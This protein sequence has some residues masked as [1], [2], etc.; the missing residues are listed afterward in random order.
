MSDA[1]TPP[2]FRLAKEKR[3]LMTSHL[4]RAPSLSL[5]VELLCLLSSFAMLG[6]FLFLPWLNVFGEGMTG[7][8]LLAEV[9][10]A[11]AGRV[12]IPALIPLAAVLSAL[13]SAISLVRP[14]FSRVNAYLVLAGGLVGVAYYALF[15]I[16]NSRAGS[17]TYMASTGFWLAFLALG[18]LIVQI[19]IPRSGDDLPGLLGA[20]AGEAS[21]HVYLGIFG[22]RS[23]VVLER[24]AGW[25]SSQPRYLA[26]FGWLAILTLIE[27]ALTLVHSPLAT[28]ALVILSGVKVLLVVAYY[29]H[30]K[31][32]SRLFTYIMLAPVPFVVVLL[33]ALLVGL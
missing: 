4:R 21:D 23:A 13:F 24:W 28:P 14:R 11:I 18:V 19:A 7:P 2:F 15:F 27:V 6:A 25:I 31:D 5:I 17:I 9:P 33:L 16:E 10:Q 29:M 1:G 32:D 12:S 8:T 22:G 20:G 30:L 3:R 26:V